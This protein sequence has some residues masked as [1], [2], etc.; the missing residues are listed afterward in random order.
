MK[1]WLTCT[2]TVRSVMSCAER[3][4]TG[5]R[6]AARVS[7]GPPGGRLRRMQLV[8]PYSRT[9]L[10]TQCQMCRVQPGNVIPGPPFWLGESEVLP[11][12]CDYCGHTLLFSL[13]VVRSTPF[14][15]SRNEE[16]LP[17]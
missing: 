5:Y 1:T 4:R 3:N 16:K 13:H 7:D 8:Y 2:S 15:D 12:T 17:Y 6:A 11:L 10:S 9:G 14:R